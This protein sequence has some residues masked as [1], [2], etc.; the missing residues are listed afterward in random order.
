MSTAV[1][2]VGGEDED[3][4]RGR[5]GIV[6]AVGLVSIVGEIRDCGCRAG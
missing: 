3:V 2:M 1:W 6:K 5:E 4:T